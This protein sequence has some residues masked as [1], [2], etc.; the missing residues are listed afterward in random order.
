[1]M[2][3][4]VNFELF[5]RFPFG[6][7]YITLPR[8]CH[9]FGRN[10]IQWRSVDKL[11]KKSLSR[12]AVWSHEWDNFTA[13]AHSETTPAD[14]GR[15]RSTGHLACARFARTKS[16]TSIR[17]PTGA[18]R[19][20]D[21]GLT[22]RG[23]CRYWARHNETRSTFVAAAGPGRRSDLAT[24]LATTLARRYTPRLVCETGP[25]MGMPG[26]DSFPARLPGPSGEPAP[27]RRP[28]CPR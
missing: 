6:I 4:K 21:L 25:E 8:R 19:P 7:F 28:K 12:D 17:R 15:T 2:P 24:T 18:R 9:T 27:K 22:T 23:A 26:R 11:S 5:C 20:G 1:M 14:P 3:G 13:S 16:T 10:E